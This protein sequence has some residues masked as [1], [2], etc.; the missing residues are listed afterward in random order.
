MAD[1]KHLRWLLEGGESWNARR[2]QEDFFSDFSGVDIY[3]EFREVGKLDSDG[4]IPLSGINLR[5]ADVQECCLCDPS[6]TKGVD[7]SFANL[8]S[9]NLQYAQPAKSR[10]DGASL[11]GARFGNAILHEASIC[12]ARMASS[13]FAEATLSG[14]N[15]AEVKFA[16]SYLENGGAIIPH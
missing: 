16:N 4:N 2:E 11:M 9:A 13:S 15:L 14:A 6:W 3:A 12:D 5:K 10:L 1:C 7:F 8:S